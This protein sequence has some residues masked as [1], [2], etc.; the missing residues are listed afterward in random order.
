MP[1][2]DIDAAA[3]WLAKNVMRYEWKG[4]STGIRPAQFPAWK[5]GGHHNATQDD[6][7]DAVRGILKAAGVKIEE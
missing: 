1:Q 7:R 3:Q 5:V 6:Y 4:M 2:L